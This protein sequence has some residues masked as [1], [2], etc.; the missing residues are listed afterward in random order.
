ANIYIGNDTIGNIGC[1]ATSTAILIVYSGL[2]TEKDFDPGTFVGMMK[3]VGGFSGN[4]IYKGKVKNAVPGFQYRSE[5]LLGKT[6]EEKTEAISYYLD[7]GYYIIA[8]VKNLGHYVAIREVKDGVV[9]MMDPAGDREVLF[10]HYAVSGVTKIFLHTSTGKKVEINPDDTSKEESSESSEYRTGIYETT[11][12]L[13]LRASASTSSNALTIIPK[14]TEITI[15]EID[16]IWGKTSYGEYEGFVC[17]T[18]AS[19]V[20][21]IIFKEPT[22]LSSEEPSSEE[23]SEE[24]SSEESSEEPSSEESSEEPLS[25]ESSEEPSSEEPSSEESSEEPSSE[26]DVSPEYVTGIYETTGSVNLRESATTSS[27][28]LGVLPKGVTV[29]VTEVIGTWGKVTY[30]GQEGYFGLKYGKLISADVD[31]GEFVETETTGEDEWIE[32]P[33]TDK[34]TK[35]NYI[36]T[37]NLNLRAEPTTSSSKLL[38]MP[39]GAKIQILEVKNGWGRLIYNG[40]EGWCSLEYCKFESAYIESSSLSNQSIIALL[41]EK[42]DVS[43]VSL[44]LYYSDGSV[45]SVKKGISIS[46]TVS[47]T[48]G[49]VKALAKYNGEEYSFNILYVDSRKIETKDNNVYVLIP[50]EKTSSDVFGIESID[51]KTS[52]SANIEGVS[53]IVVILGDV[54]GN[55]NINSSDYLRVK[56][57]FLATQTLSESESLAADVNCDG[58][59]NST[60]YLLIRDIFTK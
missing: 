27:S 6:K 24:P 26:P 35:G 29:T 18:Y 42:A 45:Y 41:S 21:D 17:L 11:D 44:N 60:D 49:I 50:S 52:A 9:Y 28:I 47:K 58:V 57:I 43:S 13:N 7:K 19:F 33:S 59:V 2:R 32:L 22:E 37:S 25:E 30:N 31:N 48:A 54:D 1:Y 10:D 39:I 38:Q 14:G 16:G 36:T 40:K 15:T 53:F 4:L 3:A 56:Q 34:Y 46:Y 12:N 55:G 8:G 51:M 20:S 5:V 23:S